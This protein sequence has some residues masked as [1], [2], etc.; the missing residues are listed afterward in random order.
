M[1]T[2]PTPHSSSG[3]S[4]FFIFR[5]TRQLLNRHRTGLS[6]ANF[7]FAEP[8]TNCSRPAAKDPDDN[9]TAVDSPLRCVRLPVGRL[10]TRTHA[11]IF[12]KH[13]RERTS[14]KTC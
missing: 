13:L 14:R 12:A 5:S 6:P 10:D 9:R 11:Q 4:F 7:N 8:R 3:F 2:S 1:K